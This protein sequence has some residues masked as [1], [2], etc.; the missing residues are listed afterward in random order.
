MSR[1]TLPEFDPLAQLGIGTQPPREVSPPRTSAAPERLAKRA[2]APKPDPVPKLALE[3]NGTH[4]EPGP[5]LETSQERSPQLAE[6][7]QSA[8]PPP[9]A[10]DATPQ[11]PVGTVT[12]LRPSK[13]KTSARVPA[14]LWE[15]V[16]D[17]VV[18][19]GHSMTVD[20]FTEDAFREQ[21]KRL[22]KQHD[23][24]ARFP[25]REH[26]PKQGRRVS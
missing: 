6:A 23:L 20:S 12:E 21:L 2:I 10:P 18:Y 15:E 3:S 22:R 8:A 13:T 19:F 16:R 17:C 11:L 1:T 26:D 24:G 9:V 25:P 14:S 7:P 5:G 4:A